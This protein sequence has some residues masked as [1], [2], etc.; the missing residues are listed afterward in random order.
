MGNHRIQ[1]D[2]M[3]SKIKLSSSYSTELLT[4]VKVEFEREHGVS[5]WD[6]LRGKTGGAKTSTIRRLILGAGTQA[7]QQLA[8]THVC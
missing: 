2:S 7:M 8:G 3:G 5:W 6:L 1:R 4:Y